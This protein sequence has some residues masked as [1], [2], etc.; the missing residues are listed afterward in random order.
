M[1]TKYRFLNTVDVVNACPFLLQVQKNQVYIKSLQIALQLRITVVSL[2]DIVHD[3]S[4]QGGKSVLNTDHMIIHW[5]HVTVWTCNSE[6]HKHPLVPQQKHGWYH[7][8]SLV[9]KTTHRSCSVNYFLQKK[10][11]WETAHMWPVRPHK[12]NRK[13]TISQ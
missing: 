13:N 9:K 10:C 7:Q 1:H 6:K 2:Y 11:E 4:A 5:Q 12:N 8:L 3:H